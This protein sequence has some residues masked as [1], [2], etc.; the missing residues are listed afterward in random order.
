MRRREFEFI[1]DKPSVLLINEISDI[2]LNDGITHYYYL[3][4]NPTR[5]NSLFD[6]GERFIICRNEDRAIAFIALRLIPHLMDSRRLAA[7]IRFIEVDIKFQGRGV[8][9]ELIELALA[10]AFYSGAEYVLS[11]VETDSDKERFL[12]KVGCKL[13]FN[14]PYYYKDGINYKPASAWLFPK[15]KVNYEGNIRLDKPII[16]TESDSIRY[17]KNDQRILV[18]RFSNV[19]DL[20]IFDNDRLYLH[21]ECKYSK[22]FA[23]Y[24]IF[25]ETTGILYVFLR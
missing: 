24:K 16:N 19:Q 10:V 17:Y 25:T 12:R 15:A 14:D 21:Q 2:Q 9:T 11:F 23:T 22:T 18:T 6:E 1:N 3:K 13:F 7:Q 20:I 4:E 8:A 5:I